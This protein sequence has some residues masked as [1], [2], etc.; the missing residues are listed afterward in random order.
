MSIG[1][2]GVYGSLRGRLAG[3]VGG[4]RTPVWV[5]LEQSEFL[6]VSGRLIQASCPGKCYSDDLPF[7]EK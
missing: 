1:W 3:A 4:A 6:R 2:P 5:L 7:S